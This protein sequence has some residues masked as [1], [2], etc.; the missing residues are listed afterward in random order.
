VW[1]PA[2]SPLDCCSTKRHGKFAAPG[3]RTPHKGLLRRRGTS[4]I[5]RSLLCLI[6]SR[7]TAG[8]AAAAEGCISKYSLASA[9]K[10]TAISMSNLR[11]PA[12]SPV[13]RNGIA[14]G[15]TDG[16]GVTSI[17][18][19]R[20]HGPPFEWGPGHTLRTQVAASAAA[21]D[22]PM[23]GRHPRI[24]HVRHAESKAS[25][26]QEARGAPTPRPAPVV[27]KPLQHPRP[28][29]ALTVM[30]AT[31]GRSPQCYPPHPDWLTGKPSVI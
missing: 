4:R 14:I 10:W 9:G 23:L 30:E 22:R 17:T 5:A 27:P 3:R 28:E 26:R 20:L 21:A 1:L 31:T 24:S 8:M 6:R 13:S 15:S 29:T 11:G 16:S 19:R 2:L 12:G 18:L 7:Q 25:A